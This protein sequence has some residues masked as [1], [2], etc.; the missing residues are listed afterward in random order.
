M[1]MEVTS[2]MISCVGTRTSIMME[3][4]YGAAN[5]ILEAVIAQLHFNSTKGELR[6]FFVVVN[7]FRQGFLFCSMK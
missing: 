6:P 5:I 4:E 3:T 1:N 2:I 7:R